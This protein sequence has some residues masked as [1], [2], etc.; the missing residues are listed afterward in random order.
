MELLWWA[1]PV[2]GV[3]LALLL[4]TQTDRPTI[5]D[6]DFDAAQR[7]AKERCEQGERV[8]GLDVLRERGLL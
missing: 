2:I 4:V 7:V 6:G 1:A 5:S 3:L 8:S